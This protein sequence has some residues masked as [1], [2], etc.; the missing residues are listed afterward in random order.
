MQDP[1]PQVTVTPQHSKS[2]LLHFVNAHVTDAIFL[3]FLVFLTEQLYSTIS[4]YQAPMW[5][6]AAYLANARA[7]MASTR[8]F[9]I[10]RPPLISWIIAAVW[11]VIGENWQNVKY[12]SAPFAVGS[13]AILYLILRSKKGAPFALGVATLTMMSPLVFFYS[14]Q[15]YTETLS[16]FFL[17]ATLY[18]TKS[19][20]P[21]FWILAGITGALTFAS[22]YPIFLQAAVIVVI[23]SYAR[24]NWQIIARAVTGATPIVAAVAIAVYLKTG[25]FQTALAKD[26]NFTLL[27][28]PYYLQ[29]SIATWGWVFLLVPMAFIL[30]ET[31]V[32]RY[33]WVFVAW[34]VFSLLF[35]SANAT[36]HDLRFTIQFTPAA[37]FI[38]LLALER[39]VKISEPLHL[40]LSKELL[41]LG[42]VSLPPL[43]RT[44][45]RQSQP[46]F[47]S[48]VASSG[49]SYRPTAY[50]GPG[51]QQPP[52]GLQPSNPR[53]TQTNWPTDICPGC[54]TSTQSDANF[55]DRCGTPLRREFSSDHLD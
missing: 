39:F 20:R 33:N 46:E 25:T 27:L 53:P 23:E 6:A 44:P 38:A 24:R 21:V 48:R 14:T 54:G 30:R 34:F 35:W 3:L 16:L 49:L 37:Y 22:R 5:D 11:G 47:P 12:L 17:L 36:N 42:R 32:N 7:W 55:C 18:F 28:S 19:E 43:G 9:E 8:L 45:M 2:R 13:A 41:F 4:T 31:Y 51:F 52:F 15:L 26:T 1:Q 29:N 10:Y 50:Q 40:F